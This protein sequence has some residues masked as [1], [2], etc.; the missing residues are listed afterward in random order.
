MIGLGFPESNEQYKK[1]I[2]TQDQNARSELAK[3]YSDGFVMPLSAL[4]NPI[5]T[6]KFIDMFPTR[7]EQMQLSTK[8]SDVV[9]L[10]GN[11]TFSYNYF[12]LEN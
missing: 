6:F 7:L 2:N 10:S 12:R 5:V 11:V 3:G 9:Y 8:L 4:N 1:F